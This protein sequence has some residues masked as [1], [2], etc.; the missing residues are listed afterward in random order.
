MNTNGLEQELKEYGL[1]AVSEALNEVQDKFNLIP[2]MTEKEV[3]ESL[4]E[5]L[6]QNAYRKGIINFLKEK[7]NKLQ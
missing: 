4:K 6:L 5:A 2:H 7:I 1:E 3:L